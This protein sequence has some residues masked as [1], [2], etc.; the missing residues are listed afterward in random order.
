[1]IKS[2]THDV[3]RI[4]LATCASARRAA[5]LRAR[6]RPA[7]LCAEPIRHPLPETRT[8]QAVVPGLP[9]DVRYWGD[10]PSA[11]FRDW[12]SVPEDEL[13]ACCAGLMDRSHNY[14]VVS[15]GGVDGAFGAGLLV[16]W[17]AAGTRPE[18]QVV[19][20]VSTGATIATLAFLG[21][22]VRRLACARS[23][24]VFVRGPGRTRRGVLQALEYDSVMDTAPLRRL[25]DLYLGDEEM[26]RIAAKGARAGSS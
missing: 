23:T 14:L 21:S 18:F 7:G 20:G 8:G 12:L 16:G 3:G 4:Y 5:R 25:I 17:T 22:A 26:A 2:P 13:N 1:M 10:D 15:S 6:C 11:A 24:R 9:A 19:T